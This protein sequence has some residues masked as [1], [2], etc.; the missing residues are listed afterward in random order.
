MRK[1]RHH[2]YFAGGK[3][4]LLDE[5]EFVTDVVEFVVETAVY[6]AQDVIKE[7]AGMFAS[8][9]CVEHRL[10]FKY[11]REFVHLVD[12]V[13]AHGNKEIAADHKINLL[14]RAFVR[15]LKGGELKNNV[16]IIRIK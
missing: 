7:K 4:M 11:F 15:M 8:L 14:L 13:V 16:E 2:L 10:C 12:G 9:V 3:D 1:C 6:L 5:S